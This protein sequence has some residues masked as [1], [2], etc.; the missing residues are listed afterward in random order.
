MVFPGGAD[1]PTFWQVRDVGQAK[2]HGYLRD[3]GLTARLEVH[4]R[5]QE[6]KDGRG[7]H[8]SLDEPFVWP[9]GQRAWFTVEGVDGGT[10]A[11]AARVKLVVTGDLD[12]L[13]GGTR[14]APL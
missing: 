4:V 12:G 5:L 3:L 6:I 11:Y 14:P 9:D 1:L 7:V 13:L 10:D 2:L 8:C